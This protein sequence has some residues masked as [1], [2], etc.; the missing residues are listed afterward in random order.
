MGAYF[1]PAWRTFG[2]R[3]AILLTCTVAGI[4]IP[5]L[6]D[7]ARA[8]TSFVTSPGTGTFTVPAGVTSIKVLLVGGG[9][10]GGSGQTF[11]PGRS[12]GGGSGRVNSLTLTV[13]PGDVID[14]VVGE[15]GA[16]DS[17]GAN[18]ILSIGAQNY[19]A[20]G[21]SAGIGLDGGHGGS[22]GGA[23]CP[24]AVGNNGGS[25]G[26]D[27]GSCSTFSGGVGQGDFGA[28]LSLFDENSITAGDGGQG[29]NP[30]PQV[31]GSGG[32]GGGILISGSGG[33]GQAGL[34]G[35]NG[36]MG[37]GA[38]GGGGAFGGNGANGLVYFEYTVP[39]APVVTAAFAA[40]TIAAGATSG[41]IITLSNP[42]SLPLSGVS[43]TASVLPPGLDLPMMGS[44]S[45]TCITG[46]PT[47]VGGAI[48]VAGVTLPANSSCTVATQVTSS[49]P[50]SYTYTTGVISSATPALTGTA[51]TTA[52]ALVVLGPLTATAL[53]PSTTLAASVAVTSF[54][55]VQGGGGSTPLTYSV[56]PGLPAGLNFDSTNGAITGTPTAPLAQT[57]F[58]VTVTDALSAT[59]SAQFQLTINEGS[60]TSL[61]ASP[62]N[63]FIGQRVTL[64]ATI[65][66]TPGGGSVLF[67]D[68]AAVL[69][70]GAVP[71]TGS[72]ATCTTSFT[73]GGGHPITATFSGAG[74]LLQ[75]SGSA[76][77]TIEDQVSK[78]TQVIGAFLSQRNNQI[79]TN[80]MD[81]TRQA[82]RLNAAS[83]GA[84]G[85]DGGGGQAS[86]FAD[87]AFAGRRADPSRD[88]LSARM[89]LLGRG[90][91]QAPSDGDA[92][93]E[94]G[95]PAVASGA[96][97][98]TFSY[99]RDSVSG[100]SQMAFSTSLSAITRYASEKRKEKAAQAPMGL[101]LSDQEAG[102]TAPF[103][104]FDIWVEG[105]YAGYTNGSG[106]DLDGHFGLLRLGADYVLNRNL[107]VGALVQFDDTRQRSDT[108]ASEV[109]GTGYLA[110]PY[111]TV[112]LGDRLYLDGRAMWGRSWN[113]VSP[114]LTYTASFDTERWLVSSSLHG[115]WDYGRWTFTPSASIA[116][117]EDNS[118]SYR[119]SFGAV[120]PS[121]KSRLGQAKVGPLVS[122]QW[123]GA[124]G[125]VM[126]PYAKAQV[127]WNFADD[128]SAAGVGQIDGDLVGP[129][130]ARGRIEFGVRTKND[131]LGL[132]LS[133]SYDGIGAGGYDAWTGRAS[134]RMP[135]N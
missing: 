106:S 39:S 97:A 112:R 121:V 63:A 15:G 44:L 91:M 49:T 122:Y 6:I 104:P 23:S 114:Y 5:A 131:G 19:V 4:V 45:T 61:V 62:A 134:L 27:G 17:N 113:D 46:G 117:M 118:E 11:G 24:V 47:I 86:G 70:G 101:G 102:A 135:L 92:R 37:F 133:G 12:A 30:S 55:P 50:G 80:D 107:L 41:L 13:N 98:G 125:A 127:I 74:L 57:A 43:V 36:G 93:D 108:D 79:L 69:C 22:G 119:D 109:E 99:D 54:V 124:S 59:A 75:S 110:G 52:T 94:D 95:M 29:G 65:A 34:S 48:S 56:S 42:N 123:V 87:N 21:G 8:E 7:R 25:D 82:N 103:N 14:Y 40:T 20:L 111:A 126:E 88:L 3:A 77:V 120:I 66:P 72:V 105:R 129:T 73:S 31:L 51:G 67:T 84:G 81:T 76:V 115:S 26:A 9:A 128:V 71:V 100:S 96:R 116:Y 53:I 89:G 132:D 78:T 58:T 35:G 85:G 64:T 32:G 130:G 2:L 1:R 83:Q 38:G 60:T 28:L 90:Q 18:T 10:G 16:Q 68:G 33:M